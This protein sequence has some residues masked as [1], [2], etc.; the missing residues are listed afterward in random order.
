MVV[1]LGATDP[2]GVLL[3]SLDEGEAGVPT[4]E[5]LIGQ[6]DRRVPLRH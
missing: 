6:A 3:R 2:V 5:L 1:A 4:I